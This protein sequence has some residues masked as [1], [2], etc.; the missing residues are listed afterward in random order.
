MPDSN[1]G[2]LP[3]NSLY[4]HVFLFY[5]CLRVCLLFLL[6]LLSFASTFFVPFFHSFCSFALS[7]FFDIFPERPVPP[8]QHHHLSVPSASRT[9]KYLFHVL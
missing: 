1:P 4:L 5:F 2:P 3:Q 9:L 7:K 8:A 6:I